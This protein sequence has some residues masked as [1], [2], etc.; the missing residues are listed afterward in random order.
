M[1]SRFRALSI[2]E[3]A[4]ACGVA[5]VQFAMMAMGVTDVIARY[6]FGRP[7]GISVR[8]IHAETPRYV[9]LGIDLYSRGQG[10]SKYGFD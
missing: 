4:L 8:A 1:L 10:H 6:A 7:I 3:K 2:A 5:L 9:R